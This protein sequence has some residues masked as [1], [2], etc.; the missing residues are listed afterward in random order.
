M[1]LATLAHALGVSVTPEW[2]K[3]KITGIS[4]DSRRITP[5]NLFVAIPGF[6]VDGH[7]YILDAVSRGAAAVVCERKLETAVPM[8][9][10]P[11][12][13]IA[14]ARLSAAF[15]DHPTRELFTV[16]V[17]GTNGKTTVC[18]LAAHLLGEGKSA[19]L[20]TVATEQRGMHAVT[21]P[22]SPFIQRFARQALSEGKENFV[23]EVSSAGLSLHRTDCVD[24][25]VAAFTNLTHDH[26][27]FHHDREAYLSAKLLLFQG[28]KQDGVA[29]INRDDPMADR[30]IAATRA[31]VITYAIHRKADLQAVDPEYQL[32]ET[33]FTLKMGKEAVQMR[34]SLPAEHN[35]YNAL[36]AFGIGLAKGLRPDEIAARLATAH[37]VVGRYQFFRAKTGA[38]VIVDFA[39][40]PDSLERMLRSLHPYYARIICVFGCGGES[41]RAK[42]PRMGRISGKLADITILTTDNPKTEDP[43]RIIAEIEAGIRPTGGTYERIV[44]RKDAIRRALALANPK[45]V[46]LLA[47]KGHEP[48]QII[49]HRFIPY[50]DA[51][52]LRANGL[53]ETSSSSFYPDQA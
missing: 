42:R 14:L 23:L 7:D 43:A 2:N 28:L 48:Y 27:D 3:I 19:L 51:G 18:H 8:I 25:D 11:D 47:G 36:A 45:D 32:K 44:D 33:S 52:F 30:F 50:S 29:I 20:S 39:H 15:Y 24:F 16:G 6:V 22:E 35:V 13:R 46:I 4:Y 5:G 1:S 12:A 49:G 38:T 40:S 31:R 21:T 10:I 41:D 17:T 9:I 26:L 34:I 37:S 53:V